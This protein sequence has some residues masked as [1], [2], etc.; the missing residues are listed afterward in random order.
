M[1]D[2]IAERI[3]TDEPFRER[4]LDWL[5]GNGID[6]NQIPAHERPTLVDGRLTTRMFLLNAEGRKQFAPSD[7]IL[8]HT[9]TLPIENEPTGD[10]ATWLAPRCPTCGR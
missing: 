7:E 8:T 1:T 5:R 6:P 4:V 3:R 2:D 10:V 9:V